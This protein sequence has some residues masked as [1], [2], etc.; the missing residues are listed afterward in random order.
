MRDLTVRLHCHTVLI[1]YVNL[2]VL[3]VDGQ[4]PIPPGREQPRR[5]PST[6][7]AARATSAR[8]RMTVSAS[9]KEAVMAFMWKWKW[10]IGAGAAAVVVGGH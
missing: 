8:Q 7:Y 2:M 6:R 9:T 10:W 1:Q 4:G 3:H 5:V